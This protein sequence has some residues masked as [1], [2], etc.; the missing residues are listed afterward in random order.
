V[1]TMGTVPL[2]SAWYRRAACRAVSPELFF[3]V[4][5]SKAERAKAVCASCEVAGE[6]LGFALRFNTPGEDVGIWGGTT[7]SERRS[8]RVQRGVIVERI[9]TRSAAETC[10]HGHVLTLTTSGRRVCRTCRRDT[11]TRYRQ[12]RLAGG[13]SG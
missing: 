3:A 10:C 5:G 13:V 2:P 4:R 9:G 11:A 12:R 8:L 1:S 6:C 7:P